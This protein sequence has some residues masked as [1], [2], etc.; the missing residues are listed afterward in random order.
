MSNTWPEPPFLYT[1]QAA[2]CLRLD[3]PDS[4]PYSIRNMIRPLL[5]GA[6]CA[7][8]FTGAGCW[9]S[10]S[11]SPSASSTVSP[12]ALTSRLVFTKGDA[13][14]VGQT[15]F[16]LGG[17]PSVLWKEKDLDRNVT[18]DEFLPKQTA[19]LSWTAE[20][21]QETEESAKA[22]TAYEQKIANRKKGEDYPPP[23]AVRMETVSARGN[24]TGID[25]LDSQTL[26]VPAYWTPG[27]LELHTQ[28][29]GI[30]L[31][32]N[33]YLELERTSSTNVYFDV[34]G[35]AATQLLQSSKDWINAVSRL[36][37]QA[38]QVS[39][40]QDPARLRL[41]GPVTDWPLTV[42]GK[43]KT[44]KVWKATNAFGQLVILANQDNPL[45]LK[46]TVN[47]VFPGAATAAQG[48]LDW[49]KLFGYEIKRVTS[50]Q[51][52]DL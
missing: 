40:R 3:I 28:Q 16:G 6:L 18:I 25:L 41:E 2:N 46:A 21:E 11:P 14:D 49:N 23:P 36:R 24:V 50:A 51:V 39:E 12:E 30:W 13:F 43:Q 32:Q 37:T 29:S 44:V 5:A 7:L 42:N 9:S 8:L 52:K 45:I 4:Y 1:L 35:E 26:S 31:S 27:V 19:S 10:L 22:R 33:A 34:S 38:A 15:F 20:T 48:S 17:L 47:P